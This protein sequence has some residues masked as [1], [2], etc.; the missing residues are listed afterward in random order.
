M[1]TSLTIDCHPLADVIIE[2]A[3]MYK[4]SLEQASKKVFTSL[5][6]HPYLIPQVER[7]L[8]YRLSK[9]GKNLK[10]EDLNGKVYTFACYEEEGII[11]QETYSKIKDT[12]QTKQVIRFPKLP[13]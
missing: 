10:G 1:K 6:V 4:M 8:K 3:T 9:V 7:E 13:A 5:F 2:F 12:C 11:S